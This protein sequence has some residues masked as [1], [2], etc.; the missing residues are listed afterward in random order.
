MC[1]GDR[2]EPPIS[3]DQFSRAQC[4]AL[5]RLHVAQELGLEPMS[6]NLRADG[7]PYVVLSV[8]E[9]APQEKRILS[10]LTVYYAGVEAEKT[11]YGSYTGDGTGEI[12]DLAHEFHIAKKDIASST[13]QN[14]Y[15]FKSLDVK[16]MTEELRAKS[17]WARSESA[18]E[19][20]QHLSFFVAL[21]RDGINRFFDVMRQDDEF[22]V[23]ET[24]RSAPRLGECVETV[25]AVP[26]GEM[27]HLHRIY[28]KYRAA[29][30]RGAMQGFAAV[31]GLTQLTEIGEAF[32][33]L[34]ALP[35]WGAIFRSLGCPTGGYHAAGSAPRGQ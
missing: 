15:D 27:H 12:E 18:L 10:W 9:A 13:P 6:I 4:R 30:A 16:K 8:P 3:D 11:L 19:E 5:A 26:G 2:D 33:Q 29:S 23:A 7:H 1:A 25:Y 17:A 22:S 34:E 28:A 35:K 14:L 32:N 20:P 31:N 24:A 21:D